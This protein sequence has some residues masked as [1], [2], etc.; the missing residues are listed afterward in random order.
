MQLDDYLDTSDGAT[1]I[2]REQASRFAK[3]VAGDFNPIHDVDARRFCV[4]GDLLFSLLLSRIGLSQEIS[5]EFTGMVDETAALQLEHNDAD[6]RL[7][8]GDKTFLTASHSGPLAASA[9]MIDALTTAYVSYSGQTF[10]HILVPL[11]REHGVMVNPARPMVMYRS[12][13]LS[14]TRADVQGIALREREASLN[15]DG[16]KGAVT[17]TFDVV[18]GSGNAVG[19]GQKHM[20]LSGLRAWDD[21]AVAGIINDYDAVKSAWQPA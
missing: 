14:L 7:Y 16:K 2:S 15:V 10:P 5:V 9:E 3:S 4:P 6:S 12:M 1:R 11:W 20:L 21:D 18:D 13:Q 17:L 8:D 19:Q